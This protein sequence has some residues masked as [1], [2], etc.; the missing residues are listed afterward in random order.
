VEAL[1][2]PRLR[3]SRPPAEAD[4]MEVL[5][6]V[7][8]DSRDDDSESQVPVSERAAGVLRFSEERDPAVLTQFAQLRVINPEKAYWLRGNEAATRWLRE[9]GEEGAAGALHVRHA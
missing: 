8:E 6:G 7:S 9:T 1:A 4:D 3:N 5:E 2:D